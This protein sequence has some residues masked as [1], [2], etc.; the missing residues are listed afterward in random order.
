LA[1]AC[2]EVEV[3]PVRANAGFLARCLQHPD[4]LAGE[5]DTGFIGARL[6]ALVDA[7][8]SPDAVTAALALAAEHAAADVGLPTEGDRYSPWQATPDGLYGFRLNAPARVT[9]R[10]EIAGETVSGDARPF[11]PGE[12]RWLVGAQDRLEE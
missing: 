10:V 6:E 4:F 8:P 11:L 2:R 7:A 12:W 5:V 9:H 1:A 3:W